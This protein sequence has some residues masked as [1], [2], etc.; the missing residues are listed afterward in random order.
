MST[1]V[2]RRK[3]RRRPPEMPRG[4]ILLESPP[5]LPELVTEGFRNV[6]TILPMAAGS[7]AMAFMFLNPNSNPIQ[8]V[9]GGMMGLSMFGMMFQQIGQRGGERKSKLNAERRDYLRYLGQVRTKV[10][11]A[12]SQQR[13]ALEW[14]NP[15]PSR[16]WSIAMSAR[17]WERRPEDGD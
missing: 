9:A 17:M 6:L 4:E 13:E 7:G 14:Y 15:D 10:R 12:A 8:M 1:V 11:K 5:E 16:L 2:V 3:E